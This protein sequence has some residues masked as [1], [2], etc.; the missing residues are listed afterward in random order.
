MKKIAMFL[1]MMVFL[2]STGLAMAGEAFVIGIA[3]HTSPRIILEMYSPLR[4]HLENTLGVPVELVT[5]P[6]FDVFAQR[7]LTQEFDIAVT[8]GHQARLLQLD[9]HYIPLLTYQAEFKAIV[10]VPKNGTIRLPADLAGKD[11]LGLSPASL[12]TLWGE[13]WLVDNKVAT[14]SIKYVSAS[15]SVAQL[16]FSGEVAAGFT[17]LANYQ[18]LEP[19][20]RDQLQV[21]AESKPLAGRVYMLNSRRAAMQEKIEAALWSFASTPEAKQYFATTKLEGYRQ[22]RPNELQEMDIYTEKTRKLIGSEK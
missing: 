1:V 15:D 10:L 11:V 13:Q 17:S 7:G 12:V 18:K 6:N 4:N 8:T 14:K 9:A 2:I 3:P 5:A 21:L 19:E 22:L 16:I 20:V